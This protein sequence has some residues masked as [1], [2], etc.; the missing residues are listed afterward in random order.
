ME[1]CNEENLETQ[2]SD[3]QQSL[4]GTTFIRT[5]F[6]G[7]NAMSGVGILSVP[8]ALSEVGWSGLILLLLMTIVCWYTGLLL[9]N[10]MIAHPFIRTYPDIGK[11]AFGYKGKVIVAFF[12]YLELYLVAIEFLILEGDNLN[13]LFP[14]ISFKVGNLK[15]KGKQGFTMLAALVFLPTTWLN[16]LELLAYI[17]AGGVLASIILVLCV[18]WV[19]AV[20]DVG[21][22][23]RGQFLKWS[24]MPTTL[25][26]YAFCY[27]G[28]AVFPTLF[29]SMRDNRQFSKVLVISFLLCTFNYASMAILGYLMY[30]DTVESQVTLNLPIKK[31]SSKIAIYTTLINPFTKYAFMIY[32]I[33]MAIEGRFQ[34]YKSKFISILIRT[35]LVIS[36]VGVALSI[37]FFG[38]LISLTGAFLCVTATMLIPCICYL[39]ISKRYCN[40]GL[41][42]L[43][44]ISILVAGSLV[45][46]LGTYVSLREIVHHM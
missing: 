8:Y 21:F 26:L 5:C 46:I 37:P 1:A 31:V 38:Y 42:W 34:Y 35:L 18:L 33:A 10:C 15:I 13:K 44:I 3:E 7:I 36:T 24:G 40:F 32:P 28:H 2:H 25:S 45:A 17:S 43:V 9:S 27:N 16:S 12:L 11:L 30:G 14:N 20:D 29:T 41:Q 39:K 19:G 6:N 22:H 23:E 4:E